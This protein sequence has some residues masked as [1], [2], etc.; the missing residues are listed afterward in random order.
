LS[1]RHYEN[2]VGYQGFLSQVE[3][4]GKLEYTCL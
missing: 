2:F 3:A 4:V 1:E